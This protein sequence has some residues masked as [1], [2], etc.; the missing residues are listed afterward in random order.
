MII[1]NGKKVTVYYTGKLETGE[2]FDT[3]VN[4]NPLIFTFGVGELIEGFE[5]GLEG[6]S[7]GEKKEVA[8]GY[9]QAYGERN[10]EKIQPV[11]LSLLPQD[12]QVGAQLQGTAPDGTEFIALVTEIDEEAQT[13]MV[14]TNHP[15]AGKNLVFEVEVVNVEDAYEVSESMPTIDLGNLEG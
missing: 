12:V 11:N 6:M 8:I 9:E 5:K 3:N 10:E 7:I 13:A 1:E 14:D 4:S 15:L 2:V